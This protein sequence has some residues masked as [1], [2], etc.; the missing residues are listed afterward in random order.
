MKARG[1][2]EELAA[3]AK[4]E[5]QRLLKELEEARGEEWSRRG[6]NP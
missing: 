1:R 4:V 3:V 5:R 2:A 6:S